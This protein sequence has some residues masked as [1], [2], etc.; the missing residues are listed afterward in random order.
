MINSF[1]CVEKKFNLADVLN[2]KSGDIF[3][4]NYG[5][6][7][8]SQ[9]CIF[10]HLTNNKNEM[11]IVF[12]VKSIFNETYWLQSVYLIDCGVVPYKDFF[13]DK[14]T[15]LGGFNPYNCLTKQPIY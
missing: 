13:V 6:I 14:K 12:A 4:F 1:C 5:T 2:L 7:Q 15:G 10:S 8:E 9:E 11:L 3:Y